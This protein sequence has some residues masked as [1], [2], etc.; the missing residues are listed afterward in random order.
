MVSSNN[1]GSG[2]R[3]AYGSLAPP[4]ANNNGE[5]ESQ[6]A[7]ASP[8]GTS[9][10]LLNRRR[11]SFAPGAGRATIPNLTA[12]MI[13]NIVGGGVWSLSG[14]VALAANDP[15]AIIT[16]YWWILALAFVFGYFCLLLAKICKLCLNAV[17]YRE[18]WQETM[19]EMGSV[20]VAFSNSSKAGLCNLMYSVILTQTLQ[21]LLETIGYKDVPQTTCLLSVTIFAIFPLCLIKNLKV[22]APFSVAGTVGV[23]FTTCVMLLRYVDGS[24][25]PGGRYYDDLVGTPMEPAFGNRNDTWSVAVLP[26][27]C[28]IFES[29][30]MHYNV[31]RFYSELQNNTIPRFSVVVTA[32][33]GFSA[34]VYILVAAAGFLTFGGN[35]DPYIINNYAASDPFVT[36]CRIA[37]GF[38]ILLTYPIAF[39]GFRDGLLDIL[40]IPHEQR[41]DTYLNLLTV[42]MLCVLTV[43]AIYITDIG[44]INAV[45]GG[46]LAS[47][48]VF[49]FPALMFKNVIRKRGHQQ[50]QQ[51]E[52]GTPVLQHQDEESSSLLRS[53]PLSDDWNHQQHE[54]IFSMLLMIGGTVLGIIGV[55]VAIEDQMKE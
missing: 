6:T 46:S 1:N 51:R 22:L 42:I 36:M 55:W 47:A 50:E 8:P 25:R 44:L 27:V 14:G 38:S 54:V 52:H 35:C 48:I 11:N 28:M 45:G 40:Q 53:S 7:L 2:A 13:K 4:S 19:G 9:T 20:L 15:K 23:L 31:P 33:F 21:S 10:G 16:C 32:S 3:T 24:Y 37:I 43:G 29:Y 30:V 39:I 41:T 17:T 49:I 26:L 18:M 34:V 5:S 12:T